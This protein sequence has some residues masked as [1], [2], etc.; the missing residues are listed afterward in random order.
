MMTYENACNC[1]QQASD[2]AKNLI[3][4]LFQFDDAGNFDG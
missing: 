3:A 2:S 1:A 4:E